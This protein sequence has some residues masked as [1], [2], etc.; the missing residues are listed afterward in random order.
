MS[1]KKVPLLLLLLFLVLSL[2]LM[3]YQSK[4]GRIAPFGFFSSPLNHL[5]S[6]LHS[7]SASVKE[8][9]RKLLLRDEENRKLNAEVSRLTLEQQRYR[10]I[11]FENQRLRDILAVREK[12]KRHAA[13]ARVI[14]KGPDIWS[15]TIVIDKSRKDGVLKDMAVIT[16]KGLV[17]KIILANGSH[18]NVL[19]VTDINFSAAVKIQETRKDAIL[20][21]TGS[22]CIL[23]YIPVEETVKEGD[24]VVTSGFD[25]LFPSEIQVGYISRTSKK[26]S[27]IFQEIEVKPFQDLTKL[28][29]VIV[30]KR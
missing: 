9:F 26:G 6:F 21:G 29:E 8:P 4:K 2:T 12:E 14:S 25:E 27:G 30:L 22:G 13:A 24:V 3:T 7:L 10:E 5:N 16:P 19:L 17:G 1:I 23:K 20:S 28:D 11:F 15:N 18:S